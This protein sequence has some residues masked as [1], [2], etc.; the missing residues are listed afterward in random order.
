MPTF[1]DGRLYSDLRREGYPLKKPQ[2]FQIQT[3][4]QNGDNW[5]SKDSE[6][7]FARLLKLA[8]DVNTVTREKK[9]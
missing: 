6:A 9:V 7:E 2:P 8:D 3:S 1:E 5:Q 4:H